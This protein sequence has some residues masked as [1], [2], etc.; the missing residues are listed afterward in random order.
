MNRFRKTIVAALALAV[1]LS[2]CGCAVK[3]NTLHALLQAAKALDNNDYLEFNKWVS[4]DNIVDQ[5]VTLLLEEG[6]ARTKKPH[7]RLWK[8]GQ[9]FARPY[10]VEETKKQFR[11]A[12]ENGTIADRISGLDQMPSSTLLF[13]LVNLFGVAKTDGKNYE[14]V[15][16]TEDKRG[17]KLEVKVKTGGEWLLLKL[18]SRKQ[19]DHYRI[20][21]V[22]NLRDVAKTLLEGYLPD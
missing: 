1:L 2:V 10:L 9:K 4:V 22:E 20:F 7:Q 8:L 21:E 14:I 18:R 16:V 13:N 11:L 19:G 15:S 3:S 6:E 12:V 17:E 5:C